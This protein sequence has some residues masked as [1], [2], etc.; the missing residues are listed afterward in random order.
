MR[1]IKGFIFVYIA[2]VCT[3][4]YIDGHQS[5][6]PLSAIIISVVSALSVY[7][8][9]AMWRDVKDFGWIYVWISIYH[10]FRVWK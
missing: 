9:I 8:Y 2:L 6:A 3:W 5:S 1:F 7:G 10:F 4:I